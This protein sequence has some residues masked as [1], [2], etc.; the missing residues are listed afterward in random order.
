TR[1]AELGTRN[2][3]ADI[4][5]A[6]ARSEF[7]VPRYSGTRISPVP[8]MFPHAPAPRRAPRARPPPRAALESG[9]GRLDR[10][11]ALG[12]PPRNRVR[13]PGCAGCGG[14]AAGRRRRRAAGA[15][16]AAPWGAGACAR[17]RAG[18]SHPGG[19][20]RDPR[21]PQPPERRS[22]ALG[23]RPGGDAAA[24]RRRA[25]ARPAG[26][27]PRGRGGRS[28][29]ELR[30]GGIVIVPRAAREP[31]AP[32]LSCPRV[33]SA[34]ESLHRPQVTSTAPILAPELARAVAA[35]RD[36]LDLDL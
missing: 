14:R 25:A 7:R 2:R 6:V 9:P 8:P 27:R 26:V 5:S 16:P 1:N 17:R 4:R 33:D 15:W 29:R 31:P 11:G 23:G 20:G 21:R 24:R 32:G 30:R 3:R 28:L 13:G 34:A 19:G 22:D 18:A 35:Q 36:R 12:A 10:A